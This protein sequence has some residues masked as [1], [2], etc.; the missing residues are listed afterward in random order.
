MITSLILDPAF[1]PVPCYIST[2]D[3]MGVVHR[4]REAPKASPSL[5]LPAPPSPDHSALM[6]AALMIVVQRR[7]SR[8]TWAASDC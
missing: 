6:F 2:A 4:L 1:L 5:F 3:F 7:T 8:F